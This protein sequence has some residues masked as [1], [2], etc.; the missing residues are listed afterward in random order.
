MCGGDHRGSWQW[1]PAV[2]LGVGVCAEAPVGPVALLPLPAVI[3]GAGGDGR[4]GLLAGLIDAAGELAVDGVR[5]ARGGDLV[6]GAGIARC[7]TGPASEVVAVTQRNRHQQ[8][9]AGERAVPPPVPPA[10]AQLMCAALGGIGGKTIVQGGARGPVRTDPPHPDL[11]P[12]GQATRGPMTPCG[13]RTRYN[14]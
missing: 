6:T 5:P 14:A 1:P 7:F 13:L 9:E 3:L 10:P 4:N 11:P 8:C 2:G 12:P